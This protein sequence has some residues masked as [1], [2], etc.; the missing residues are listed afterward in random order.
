MSK[1]FISFYSANFYISTFFEYQALVFMET[2]RSDII[3]IEYQDMERLLSTS[4]Q[5]LTMLTK[6][7][8]FGFI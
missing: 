6:L 5:M 7:P 8:Y 3:I 4:F 2:S 1:E